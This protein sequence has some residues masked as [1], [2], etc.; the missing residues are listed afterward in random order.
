M[1]TVDFDY[2][3]ITPK[4]IVLDLGCGAGRHTFE[5]LKRQANVISLDL[6]EL[7]AK[8]VA[9][10]IYAMREENQLPANCRCLIISSDALT[11]P[12]K[13]NSVDKVIASE[14][15]EHIANDH[16][17][18]DELNRVLIPGGV[19]ALTV[20]RFFPELVNWALADEY[21]LVKGGHVRIYRKKVLIQRL[22]QHGFT[23]ERIHYNHGL[24]S[25]YWWLKCFVGLY[26]ESNIF[27]RKY[28][29]YLERQIIK[30]TFT[31]K[32]L[33]KV[34]SSLIGKSIV[35]YARKVR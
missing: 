6:D 14:V 18:F 27:V 5:A 11:L 20:P 9:G 3:K 34:L 33:D 8:K 4:E 23:V 28:K 15:L 35:V 30:P 31:G 12:F 2:L 7:E 29:S 25:P 10:M 26:N 21:H 32:F 17:A 13:N 19:L 24:H 1:L 22:V 16:K